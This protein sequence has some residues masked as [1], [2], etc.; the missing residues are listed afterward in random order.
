MKTKESPEVWTEP[1]LIVLV[2][3]KPEE[4]VLGLCKT[5][6]GQ[7]GPGNWQ[8]QCLGPPIESCP[9]CAYPEYS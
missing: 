3:S 1:E 5:L 6:E 9:T 8:L 2:R 4:T 7:D